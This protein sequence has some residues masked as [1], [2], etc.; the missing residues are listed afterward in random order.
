[1]LTETGYTLGLGTYLGAGALLALGSR[2]WLLPRSAPIIG[3]TLFGVLLALLLTPAL[4]RP[5]MDS[6]APAL[7]VA[8]F[9]WFTA[10][11]EAAAH[12]LRPLGVAVAAGAALGFCY[13]LLRR[14]L[15]RRP[16]DASEAADARD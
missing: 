1:M 7:V 9:Q 8:L 5:G 14:L 16:V 2:R 3:G 13:G 12:A 6:F 10:G 15:A 11:P 4:A